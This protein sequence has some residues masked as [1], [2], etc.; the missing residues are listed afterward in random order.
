MDSFEKFWNSGAPR[1]G[2]P[3]SEGWSEAS[4]RQE[5][6][7]YG[8]AKV[9]DSEEEEMLSKLGPH[10]ARN[11]LWLELELGRERRHWLPWRPSSKDDEEEA[12]DPERM[13][14]FGT[15]APFLFVFFEP[16]IQLK[17]FLCAFDF[18]VGPEMVFK[19]AS[20]DLSVLG[21]QGCVKYLA[22]DRSETLASEL[23]WTGVLR[24][25]SPDPAADKS[26]QDFCRNAFAQASEK[27]SEPLRTELT[28]LWIR[29]ELRV[30]SEGDRKAVKNLV[31]KALSGRSDQQQNLDIYCEY[32][33][34]EYA[35]GGFKSAWKVLEMSLRSAE[36][37]STLY[38]TAIGVCLRELEA[39]S[40]ASLEL[41]N[42]VL[43][44][45]CLAGERKPYDA[46]MPDNLTLLSRA[47]EVKAGLLRRLNSQ[48]ASETPSSEVADMQNRLVSHLP[49]PAYHVF[50]AAWITYF[51]DG[52]A[53][54]ATLLDRA[55]AAFGESASGR[56]KKG[57][58]RFADES[59]LEVLHK[60]R[61]DALNL[62][63]SQGRIF[64]TKIISF[65]HS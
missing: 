12:D 16:R 48:L 65:G 7:H 63:R 22:L 10:V 19:T 23:D 33:R 2:E 39:S 51:V 54:M 8:A 58:P 34:S 50:L 35:L 21:T 41:R 6:R 25:T 38:A 62:A 13:V 47:H 32:A 61:L 11:S 59:V 36:V 26:Y 9:D 45:L 17:M 57:P 27:A 60:I 64:K 56:E 53:A 43:W 42:R 30:A 49:A 52:S 14:P 37:S 5:K 44:L 29:F 40:E 24:R 4:K 55:I 1:F 15:I 18:L 46:D 28:L 20:F 3:G 31:K